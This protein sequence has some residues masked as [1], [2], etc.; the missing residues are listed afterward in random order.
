MMNDDVKWNV[1]SV[2]EDIHYHHDHWIMMR[3]A[4]RIDMNHVQN[5]HV[6]LDHRMHRFDDQTG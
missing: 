4:T 3:M 1:E 6:A 2:D 5:G